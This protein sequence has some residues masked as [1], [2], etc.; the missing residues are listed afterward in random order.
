MKLNRPL[1][2]GFLKEWD[3]D[4]LLNK[5]DTWSTRI[6]LVVY[7]CLL[8]MIALTFICFVVPNDPR[9]YSSVYLWVIFVSLISFVG[10]IVWLIFLLRFNVFK[11]FGNQGNLNAIKTFVFFFLC[12]GTMVLCPFIPPIVESMRANMKYS[13]QEIASDINKINSRI[14]LLEHDSIPLRWQ[15]D[16]IYV[17]ND[18]RQKQIVVDNND[19]PI[20]A[21][22][23]RILPGFKVLDTAEFN[24]KVQSV[25]SLQKLNDSIYLFF[26]CPNY[27][28]VSTY[29]PSYRYDEER[30]MAGLWTSVKL[31]REVLQHYKKTDLSKTRKELMDLL[32]KYAPEKSQYSY[33]DSDNKSYESRISRKYSLPPVNNSLYNIVGRKYRW[34]NQTIRS[35]IEV[36]Y[37]VTL[38]LS[39]FVFIYRRTSLRTFFL[40]L[41]A[42]ILVTI[43]TSLAGAF[44]DIRDLSLNV[45]LLIYYAI[46][47]I[48]AFQQSRKTRNVFS[49]IALNFFVLG[50]PFIPLIIVAM[51]YDIIRKIYLMKNE[52]VPYFENE[53]RNYVYSE[54]AGFVLL[55]LLMTF[56]FRHLYRKWFA[57]PE[58]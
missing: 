12:T 6:H 21:T 40:S 18:L 48:L 14:L 42:A 22:G 25:D 44:F 47:C 13:G 31:Y 34:N 26:E 10:F 50:T 43:F 32:L 2:P 9:E 20:D 15:K 8:F 30:S 3:R 56:V 19:Y 55:L 11:R 51:A 24:R 35:S 41:L 5:P 53:S 58:Q 29:I 28:F 36:F 46:F 7:Y 57:Q 4:L 33:Y 17:V 23:D 52:V 54:I 45:L 39:M 1:C 38:V 49:G 27:Q 16:T 37:Y